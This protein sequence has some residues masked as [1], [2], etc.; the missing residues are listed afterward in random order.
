MIGLTVSIAFGSA[1][2]ATAPSQPTFKIGDRAP[3]IEPITWLQGNPVTKYLSGRV[4]VVEFW[5]TW[6]PPCIKAIPHLSELQ[7][8]YAD[9][10]TV[11]GV[12]ADGLLGF[13]AKVDAVRDFMKKHG[14]EMAYT[15]AMDDPIKKTMSDTWITA[16]GSMGAPTAFIIDQQGKLAWVGY[17]NVAQGYSFDHALKDTLAGKTDLVGARALQITTSHETAKYLKAGQKP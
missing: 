5:A 9:R 13:E 14:K 8:K 10:L 15:V 11:V 12:N 17:P 3:A 2:V 7:K 6:C 1:T 4:Y 16:S